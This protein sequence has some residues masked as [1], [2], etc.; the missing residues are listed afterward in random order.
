MTND[1]TGS[2]LNPPTDKR[3]PAN[4]CHCQSPHCSVPCT[5]TPPFPH[6]SYAPNKA[7]DHHARDD[8]L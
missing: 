6:L 7:I 2:V 1:V 5:L 8:D 3:L 4:S